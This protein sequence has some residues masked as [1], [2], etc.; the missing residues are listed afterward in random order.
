M[1]LW[2][3]PGISDSSNLQM[4]F[5]MNDHGKKKK[6][7]SKKSEFSYNTSSVYIALV[8]I[9]TSPVEFAFVEL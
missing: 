1:L 3:Y 5:G 4:C 2:D 7:F 8:H 9:H 6:D